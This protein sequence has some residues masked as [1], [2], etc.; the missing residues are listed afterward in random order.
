MEGRHSMGG[1]VPF[2][3]YGKVG[4]TSRLGGPSR[5]RRVCRRIAMTL[6]PWA[7]S[8]EH[9]PMR[10]PMPPLRPQAPYATPRLGS[11]SH[12]GI[13]CSSGLAER[14]PLNSGFTSPPRPVTKTATSQAFESWMFAVSLDPWHA[15]FASG[16]VPRKTLDAENQTDGVS[17]GRDSPKWRSRWEN[18]SAI[19]ARAP[20]ALSPPEPQAERKA[21][22]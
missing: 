9:P 18:V 11:G 22:S 20:L 7:V 14:R 1:L 16:S 12:A 8:A 6:A 15:W 3:E 19:K 10:P 13:W 17:W 5:S 2:L 21:P 4:M